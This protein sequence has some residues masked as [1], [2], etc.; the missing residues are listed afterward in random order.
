MTE[1]Q[2]PR[3]LTNFT[4]A[5]FQA[6]A[7]GQSVPAKRS[8]AVNRPVRVAAAG[9][10]LADEPTVKSSTT[11]GAHDFAALGFVPSPESPWSPGQGVTVG[12]H[13]FHWD[14]DAW[15]PG[16]VKQLADDTVEPVPTVED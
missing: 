7:D 1:Q 8:V 2:G 4:V 16:A 15:K 12:T 9:A 11:K 6:M 10:V 13:V 14:G 3:V 5:D